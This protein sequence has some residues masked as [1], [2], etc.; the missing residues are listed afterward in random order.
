MYQNKLESDHPPGYYPSIVNLNTGNE[1]RWQA[2][3][4]WSN[5]GGFPVK[6]L[7][8]VNPGHGF[9]PPPGVYPA[10]VFHY[11]AGYYPGTGDNLGHGVNHVL[12]YAAEAGWTSPTG[13]KWWD[14]S[15]WNTWIK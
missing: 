15:G 11:A 10:G 12:S 1:S 2:W 13:W 5:P 14:P 6:I 9:Y 8:G 3:K 7:P 4:D